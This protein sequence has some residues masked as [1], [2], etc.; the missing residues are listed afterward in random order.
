MQLIVKLK[1][2]R[3]FYIL[4]EERINVLLLNKELDK[5]KN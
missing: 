2:N 5:I 4:G 1:E 3:Q